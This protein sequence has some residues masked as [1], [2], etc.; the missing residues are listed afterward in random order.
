MN[1]LDKIRLFAESR[2]DMAKKVLDEF[3]YF[4]DWDNIRD[5]VG[6][7]VVLAYKLGIH[8]SMYHLMDALLRVIETE[9]EEDD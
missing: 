8:D 2:R 5:L 6:D 4:K 3:G 9:I 7:D 1:E